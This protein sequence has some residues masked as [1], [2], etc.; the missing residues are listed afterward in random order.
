MRALLL[1]LCLI[2][3]P[4][5]A[6]YP[7]KAVRVVVPFPPGGA[8][9]II[10]RVVA[11][12]MSEHWKQPVVVENRP[13]AGGTIGS[14]LVAKAA[15]DGY[16]L[17]IATHRT[18]AVAAGLRPPPHDPAK[19]FTPLTLLAHSPNL[20]VVGAGSRIRSPRGLVPPAQAP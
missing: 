8:T 1:L 2:S 15:P 11:Q 20:L 6:Q 12:K 19:D 9:D 5:L 16:T 10:S 7:N 14:D 13:G 17:L 4:A 18:Q 3:F